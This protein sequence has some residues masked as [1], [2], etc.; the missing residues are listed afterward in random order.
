MYDVI[1]LSLSG[2]AHG[3]AAMLV[4]FLLVQRVTQCLYRYNDCRS[5]INTMYQETRKFAFCNNLANR[6]VLFMLHCACFFPT[7]SPGELIQDVVVYS[8]RNDDQASRDWR[9]EVAYRT[10]LLLRA[11]VAVVEYNVK[12][13]PAWKLTELRGD[14]KDYVTPNDNWARHSLNSEPKDEFMNTMKVPFRLEHMLRSSI[15]GQEERLTKPIH[16]IY[17]SKLLGCVDKFMDGFYG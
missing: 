12:Q 14:E 16:I 8:S 13:Q 5:Y 3:Y 7:L 4:S 1:D 2:Q 15:Y 17:E 6:F 11:V 10:L 9:M